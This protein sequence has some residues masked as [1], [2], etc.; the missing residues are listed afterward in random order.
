MALTSYSGLV[1]YAESLLNRA[2]LTALVPDFLSMAEAHFNREIRAPQMEISS[3][4]TTTSATIALPTDFLSLRQVYVD[5]DNDTVLIPLAAADLRGRYALDTAG[6]PEAYSISGGN[7]VLAPEP[8]ASTDITIAYY[9]TIP[10]LTVSNTTNWLLT[11]HPDLYVW[12]IRY[13]AAEHQMDEALAQKCL[14]NVVAII[15]SLNRASVKRM[16]PAGP[17]A[18]RPA[19]SE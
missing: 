13:Y 12:A 10:A 7:I 14:G 3:T 18:T 8:S 15:D 2:D 17:L 1:T 19:V 5:D 9:Q 11:A 6:V 4:S 16:A